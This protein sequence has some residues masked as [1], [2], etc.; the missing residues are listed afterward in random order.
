M[1]M[2]MK[3]I[4]DIDICVGVNGHNVNEEYSMFFEEESREKG[5][6]VTGKIRSTQMVLWEIFYVLLLDFSSR[7]KHVLEF[8]GNNPLS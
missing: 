6:T 3:I 1:G 7:N 8:P 4:S 5:D 2:E